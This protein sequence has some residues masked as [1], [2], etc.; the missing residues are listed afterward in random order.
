MIVEFDKPDELGHVVE[1]RFTPR[2]AL[3]DGPRKRRT[4]GVPPFLGSS[5]SLV[6]S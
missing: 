1:K 4:S 5:L 6:R 3:Q 2:S